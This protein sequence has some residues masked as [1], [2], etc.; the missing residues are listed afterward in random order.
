[1]NRPH[2][3]T[4]LDAADPT[5][6]GRAVPETRES[7]DPRAPGEVRERRVPDEPSVA[8]QV[9]E[10]AGGIS[11]VVAG[12]AIG[13]LGGPVG[14]LIGGVAGA[15]GGWWAGRALADAAS[16][17]TPSDDS[18]YREHFDASATPLADRRYEDVR[19]AYVLGHLAGYNPDYAGREFEEI[20]ADLER[21]WGE[22]QRG[23]LGEWASL[24]GYARAGYARGR[25]FA[26]GL[27]D[28]P[29]RTGERSGERQG[30]LPDRGDG[31]RRDTR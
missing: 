8:D 16:R 24:R 31:A 3:R 29:R 2:D 10:A 15:I 19:P 14:A 7:P 23:R 13:S 30:E 18:Y 11:G 26:E 25:T 4:P 21:G 27:G 1:M 9:G 6:R 12:A 22:D 28:L 17:I 5:D 20:E